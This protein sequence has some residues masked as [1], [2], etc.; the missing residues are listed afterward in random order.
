MGHVAQT[1]QNDQPINDAIFSDR[2]RSRLVRLCVRLTGDP[3]VAEDLVQETLVTA[4]QRYDQVTDP[5]GLS[6]W[7]ATIA[8]N[9]Y[10]HWV[11][12]RSRRRNYIVAANELAAPLS[13][14]EFDV[15]DDFDLDTEL[16]R[17]QIGDLLDRAMGHLSTETQTLLVNHYIEEMP[18]AELAARMRIKAGAVA[19]RLH[20]G[21][22]VLR[23]LLVTEFSDDALA[24]GLISSDSVG[25]QTTRIWCTACGQQRLRGKFIDGGD[26]QFILQCDCG[27]NHG[28]SGPADL[29]DG[30]RGFRPA[31][32]RAKQ[33]QHAFLQAGL[34]SGTVACPQC[35]H[36]IKLHLT[37]Q[38]P[39]P[40]FMG[41]HAADEQSAWAHCTACGWHLHTD[42]ESLAGNFPEKVR[43]G[44]K[45][46]RIKTLPIHQIDYEGA[47]A[48]LVRTQSITDS[49]QLDL[50]FHATT[51]E[52]LD[53]S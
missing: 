18:Q 32:T 44:R 33:W 35:N 30:V 36:V 47:P 17:A 50:I 41:P 51:F 11:R 7:L 9:H 49:T 52:L 45:H 21:K 26:G 23:Q 19:G 22:T 8:R 16:D 4:W 53:S 2:E 42:L 43:F 5:S 12:S 48:S 20:R 14:G 29:L 37:A 28:I 25:W 34:R 10:R 6:A 38:T 24:L 39:K 46:P 1:V 27:A 40:T 13:T 15:A 31:W 3:D